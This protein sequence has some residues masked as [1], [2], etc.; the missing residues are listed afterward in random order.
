MSNNPAR[1]RSPRASC[2][3]ILLSY[4]AWRALNEISLIIGVH[5]KDAWTRQSSTVIA[6][7]S[8]YAGLVRFGVCPGARDTELLPLL[9]NFLW[10]TMYSKKTDAKAFL[11]KIL[12][13]LG[14]SVARYE[15]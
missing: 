3:D 12:F 6:V 10:R 14:H 1:L 7:T 9:V 11:L 15:L 8:G 4:L 13:I 2:F 5:S